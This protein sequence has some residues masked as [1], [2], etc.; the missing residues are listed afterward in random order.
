MGGK[1]SGANLRPP[2]TVNNFVAANGVATGSGWL[3]MVISCIRKPFSRPGG[4][5][6]LTTSRIN[7]FELIDRPAGRG[8]A[9]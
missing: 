5:G 2:P 7:D 8:L 6:L 4:S 3:L 9:L 1:A